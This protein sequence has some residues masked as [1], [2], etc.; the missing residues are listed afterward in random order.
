MYALTQKNGH[1][2]WREQWYALTSKAS[3]Q[4]DLYMICEDHVFIATVVVID[5]TRK[6]VGLGVIS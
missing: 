2:V 1:V 4:V 5:L 3:L 6:I